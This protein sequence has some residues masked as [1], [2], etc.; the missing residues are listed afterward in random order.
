MRFCAKNRKRKSRERR[1]SRKA[2]RFTVNLLN[3]YLKYPAA[4][5]SLYTS[6]HLNQ[7]LIELSL[8]KSY[9]ESGLGNLS[10]KCSQSN[11]IP[12]G[13]T[14][15]GRIERLDEKQIREAIIGANDQVLLF[16][17]RYGIFRRKAIVAID[18]TRQPFYGDPDTKNVIGGKQE[19]GT[20]WGY[21]YASIDIVEAGK[22]LT[23]YCASINQFS[24]KAQVVKK[25]ILEAKAK[26]YTSASCCLTEHSSPWRS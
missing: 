15:R 14:F 12:T 16:L 2:F 24:E 6:N 3:S 9:A 19:R 11:K 17:R 18:Y 26:G 23:L 8:S 25:L 20:T 21:T 5:N 13:R 1:I 4:K 10:V 7:C 22:R